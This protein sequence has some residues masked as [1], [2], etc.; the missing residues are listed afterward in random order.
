ML[1]IQYNPRKISQLAKSDNKVSFVGKVTKAE[2]NSLV[3]QDDTGSIGIFFEGSAQ[4]NKLIR[5][6]CS[7]IDQK[8]K[9]DIV[10]VLDGFD[11][12]LFKRIEELY[13]RAG[14]SV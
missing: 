9:A 1:T 5:V 4:T 14:L 10:Q 7:I 8:P 12:N 2:E 3:L 6:F 13:N 11:L